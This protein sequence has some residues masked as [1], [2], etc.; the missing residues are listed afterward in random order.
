M[1]ITTPTLVASLL[2][3]LGCTSTIAGGSDLQTIGNVG[4]AS[5]G[6]AGGVSGGVAGAS[7][8][9]AGSTG[10]TVDTGGTG[11]PCD[12]SALLEHYCVGCHSSPP[13]GGAP[14]ALL[15]HDNLVATATLDSTQKVGAYSVTLMQT[16]V[17]P[18]KPAAAPTAT[19]QAAFAAWVTAGMPKEACTTPVDAGVVATNPYDTPLKCTSGSTWTRGDH[20][21][22][23][24]H[25]G[26]TCISCHAMGGNGPQYAVAGT[27]F[28][29]AHEPDDC[30]GTSTSSAGG[31]SVLITEANGTT[32]TLA[33]NS[34][35]NFYYEG[36]I[37]TP[38]HAQVQ[39]GSVVR[40]MTHTQT[41]GDCNGC[42][43]VNGSSNTPGAASAPGR[44][45]A[46]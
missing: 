15:S 25:P 12:V 21:S 28:P 37:T 42:H 16:G 35:G 8:G 43:T 17:M 1:R 34:V 24:M 23:S 31:L 30:N 36:S 46:P 27:V 18:P 6:S 10:T 4:G 7:S 32:H 26:G 45:M 13:V 3:T 2:L 40:V 5:S 11:L 33:V 44:I 39:A 38:Y 14:E 22:S 41:S 19:E 20:G 29:S 9:S